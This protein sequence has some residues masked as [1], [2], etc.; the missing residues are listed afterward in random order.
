MSKV[1]N[2]AEV[3]YPLR[4]VT[5]PNPILRATSVDVVEFDTNLLK[6]AME[7]R[8]LMYERRGLGIAA[9]Q[10][11]Y[12]VNLLVV[13]VTFGQDPIFL[14][15]PKVVYSSGQKLAEEGCL[16]FKGVFDKVKSPELLLIEYQDLQGKLQHRVFTSLLATAVNHEM[17]HLTGKLFVDRMSKKQRI[18]A[19]TLAIQNIN[20]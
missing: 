10:V 16:S 17:D 19:T 9:P 5:Y 18:R 8:T 20:K 12:N 13:D 15:N 11:G 2:L 14:V 7:M 6:L 3:S 1:S 4:L